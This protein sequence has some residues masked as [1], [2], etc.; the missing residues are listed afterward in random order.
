[1]ESGVLDLVDWQYELLNAVGSQ[2]QSCEFRAT[3]VELR[4]PLRIT[5]A[6][7]A[8]Y[9]QTISASSMQGL[10]RLVGTAVGLRADSVARIHDCVGIPGAIYLVQEWT[11]GHALSELAGSLSEVTALAGLRALVDSC[12]VF[13]QI[14]VDMPELAL[15]LR[16]QSD[17]MVLTQDERWVFQWHHA[18]EWVHV[19]QGHAVSS[20]Q[21]LRRVLD[22]MAALAREMCVPLRSRMSSTELA[23]LTECLDDLQRAATSEACVSGDAATTIGQVRGSLEKLVGACLHAVVRSGSCVR[24]SVLDLRFVPG[25][26][27][28]MELAVETCKQIVVAIRDWL[29]MIK[30]GVIKASSWLAHEVLHHGEMAK[31]VWRSE[32]RSIAI[33]ARRKLLHGTLP[34]GNVSTLESTANR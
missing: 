20:S 12:A 8:G 30:I 4:H 16:L 26:A 19:A 29:G 18:D 10:E 15:C 27:V 13:E 32:L 9:D 33:F 31:H 14:M 17:G 25:L 22:N 28:R 24:V 21:V 34:Q 5:V 3:H 7:N 6:K 23:K 1:M 11:D 2:A